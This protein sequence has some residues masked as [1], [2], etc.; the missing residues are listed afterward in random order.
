[1]DKWLKFED[2]SIPDRKTKTV[3]VGAVK[4]NEY[5]GTIEYYPPWRQ[6]VFTAALGETIWNDECLRELADQITALN[7]GGN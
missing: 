7:N 3:L 6:Y 5:L 1:M 4:T 2:D